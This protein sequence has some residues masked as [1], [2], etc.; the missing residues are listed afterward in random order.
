M[1]DMQIVSAT[2][3]REGAADGQVLVQLQTSPGV[4]AEP[5]ASDT[6][7]FSL[8]RDQTKV[9]LEQLL[10]A[11]GWLQATL[12]EYAEALAAR[13]QRSD[14]ARSIEMDPLAMREH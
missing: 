12:P 11:A 13:R 9:L 2:S 4:D 1:A 14:V 7:E 10:R 5:D 3:A 8:N 6:H